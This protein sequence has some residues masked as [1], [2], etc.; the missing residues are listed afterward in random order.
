MMSERR[1]DEVAGMAWWNEL[2]EKERGEWLAMAQSVVPATRGEPTK[3]RLT[4]MR[5]CRRI[6]EG[7]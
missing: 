3:D 5:R 7:A 6:N 4:K 2:T 1:F